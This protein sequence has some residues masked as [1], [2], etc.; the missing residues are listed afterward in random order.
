[1]K[2]LHL[3]F[4]FSATLAIDCASSASSTTNETTAATATSSSGASGTPAVSA[5]TTDGELA[6][7]TDADVPDASTAP[8]TTSTSQQ[9]SPPRD[10]EEEFA[11]VDTTPQD[12]AVTA[13]HPDPTRPDPRHGTFTL[14]QATAG[15]PAGN[16]LVAEIETSMG[17]FT[18]SLLEREAPETVANFVGLARGVRDFWDPTAG[19]WTRRP[20][21]DG[22]VFHRVIPGFMVQGGDILRSGRGGPGYT[23]RDENVDAHDAA[24][25]LCMANRGPNTG[26]AQFFVTEVPLPR[27][28]GSYSVFGRCRPLDLVGRIARTPRS[29]RDQPIA[30]VTITHVTVHR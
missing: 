22:S 24:G 2:P 28:N 13:R 4:A 8:A 16:G 12:V 14:A 9:A 11:P 27:L 25:L 18:C 23:I 29:R 20:F 10:P 6:T 30:P 15:L 3:L 19:R 5:Q 21:Y 1:M 17:T 7:P 26:G